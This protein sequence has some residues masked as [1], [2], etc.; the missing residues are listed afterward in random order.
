MSAR[1]EDKGDRLIVWNGNTA[2]RGALSPELYDCILEAVKQAHDRRIRTVIL[3]S[4]GPFFCAGGDLNVLIER[5]GLPEA[6]RREKIDGLHDLIRAIRSCPVPVIAA[7]EGGAAGAGLSLALAC[8]LIVAS[9]EARFTA[10]YV[11]AGLVPDGGLTSAM[12]RM[13]PRPL[14]ME[15]CLM[16]RPVNALRFA[17]LGAVNRISKPDKA[18]EEAMMLADGLADGPRD[19]QSTIRGLVADA[20]ETTEAEQLD[21][22]RNAMAAASGKDEAAEG[23]AAFLEKRKPVYR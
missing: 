11:K 3:T 18:L 7:V 2:K 23:I 20:Y 16:G 12:A 6:E 1:L 8:D 17:E 13:L 19:A 15:M 9:E 21:A 22:E 10:A 4:E 14:A 5:R